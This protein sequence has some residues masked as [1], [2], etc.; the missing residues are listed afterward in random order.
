MLESQLRKGSQRNFTLQ[1]GGRERAR[2]VHLY[3]GDGR[4]CVSQHVC[5][6]ISQDV[7]N[8]NNKK[9]SQEKARG[10]EEGQTL[11]SSHHQFSFK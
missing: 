11:E 2:E 8:S 3:P 6:H 5:K 9:D 7:N 4:R 1:P 10:R